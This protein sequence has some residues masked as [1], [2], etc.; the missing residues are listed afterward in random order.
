MQLDE[1]RQKI[2]RID[3]DLVTLL[4]ARLDM[5]AAIAKAKQA[6]GA[7]LYDPE[8]EQLKL[9]WVSE[10]VA[11]QRADTMRALFTHI[12][13]ANKAEQVLALRQL[14]CSAMPSRDA[15]PSPEAAGSDGRHAVHE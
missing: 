13:D 7:P 8:R 1:L 9:A 10:R 5:A 2:D 11:P 4:D 3:N 6:T 14:E 15:S 12:M